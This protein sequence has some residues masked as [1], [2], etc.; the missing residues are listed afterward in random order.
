VL[1]DGLQLRHRTQLARRAWRAAATAAAEREDEEIWQAAVVR[2]H[3]GSRAFLRQYRTLL[4]LMGL[5]GLGMLAFGQW[6]WLPALAAW[7]LVPV[8]ARLRPEPGTLIRTGDDDVRTEHMAGVSVGGLR[9]AGG[10]VDDKTMSVEGP[11]PDQREATVRDRLFG[12]VLVVLVAALACATTVWAAGLIDGSAM[13]RLLFLAAGAAGLWQVAWRAPDRLRPAEPDEEAAGDAAGLGFYVQVPTSPFTNWHVFAAVGDPR[14]YGIVYAIRERSVG[15]DALTG[16]LRRART[17]LQIVGTVLFAVFFAAKALPS[18]Q[19]G[20][21]TAFG[22]LAS[23][24]IGMAVLG[25]GSLIAVD[26]AFRSLVQGAWASLV[27]SIG[28]LLVVAALIVVAY[29]LG[30]LES[31]VSLLETLGVP[32]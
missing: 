28:Y 4:L 13:L 9:L 8:F 20:V 31:W 3:P 32:G 6:R 27:T 18:M 10:V 5:V 17:V 26:R 14:V 12:T 29:R 11:E 16:L 7:A 25:I 2:L 24:A 30:F 21:A 19:E 1:G 15:D 22:V 23:A